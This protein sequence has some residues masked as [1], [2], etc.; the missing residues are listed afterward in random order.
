M[1]RVIIKNIPKVFTEKEITNHFKQVDDVTDCKIARNQQGASRGFAFVGFRNPQTAFQVKKTY[2]NTYIGTTKV[3]IDIA[4]LKNEESQSRERS[5]DQSKGKKHAKEQEGKT[6]V[7]ED[8][9]KMIQEKA[10]KSWDDL[11]VPDHKHFEEPEKEETKQKS[12]E[13]TK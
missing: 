11:V 6:R 12:K 8:Y 1:S 2:D 4:K 13:K 10:K 7:F 9:K 5:R 3:R